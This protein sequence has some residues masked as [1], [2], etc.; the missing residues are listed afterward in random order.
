MELSSEIS[1]DTRCSVV[2]EVV[3]IIA[4]GPLT[5]LKS[6]VLFEFVFRRVRRPFRSHSVSVTFLSLKFW[7]T[8]QKYQFPLP[9]WRRNIRLCFLKRCKRRQSRIQKKKKEEEVLT[10]AVI[11]NLFSRNIYLV[12]ALR[13][14]RFFMSP[15]YVLLN[16][17]RALTK[18]KFRS[19]WNCFRRRICADR[20]V[21]PLF[22]FIWETVWQCWRCKGLDSFL[23]T[24]ENRSSIDRLFTMDM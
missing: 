10:F 13:H 11:T 24:F 1:V 21:I 12:L 8:W 16:S 19:H 3:L 22:G 14:N 7:S 20:S 9:Q 6:L 15:Y 4:I 23:F 18:C 2:F 5:S 17:I